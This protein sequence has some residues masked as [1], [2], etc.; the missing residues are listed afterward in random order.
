[1][2]ISQMRVA[3]VEIKTLF[4]RHPADPELSILWAFDALST[5]HSA[6]SFKCTYL[7]LLSKRFRLR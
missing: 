4:G 6:I 5:S 7:G 2:S 1:M 3:I